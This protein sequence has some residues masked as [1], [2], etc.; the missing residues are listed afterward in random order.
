MT[1]I[2]GNLLE[3]LIWWAFAVCIFSIPLLTGYTLFLVVNLTCVARLE[4]IGR[5]GRRT[6]SL[7]IQSLRLLVS[8]GCPTEISN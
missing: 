5:L 2:F 7:E 4:R 3:T 8:N 1:I 6:D